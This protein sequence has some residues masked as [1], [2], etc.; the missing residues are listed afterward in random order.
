[1]SINKSRSVIAHL[2][3]MI[4]AIVA[5]TVGS[6]ALTSTSANAAII[7]ERC[8]Y[9]SSQPALR[10]GSR[11]TAVKQMQCEIN[12]SMYHYPNIAVDG[13]FGP[14]TRNAVI[15]FQRCAGITVDGLVGPQTWAYLNYWAA[16]PGFC[17]T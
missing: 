12:F 9:T 2:L 7:P 11:G 1:M 4:T 8:E 6:V 5:L 16:S 10:Y 17:D 14:A 3:A 15:A 13:S